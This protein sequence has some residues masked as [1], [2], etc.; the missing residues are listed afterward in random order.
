MQQESF[1]CALHVPSVWCVT[2]LLSNPSW[3]IEKETPRQTDVRQSCTDRL[4]Y[5]VNKN[6]V[7]TD[8]S[9]RNIED[10]QVIQPTVMTLQHC[11]AFALNIRPVAELRRFHWEIHVRTWQTEGQGFRTLR[12]MLCMRKYLALP[13]DRTCNISFLLL[14]WISVE[15]E[16]KRTNILP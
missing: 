4:G 15:A 8:D 9:S 16:W 7:Y 11:H 5:Y 12:E 13:V 2:M 1:W 10:V 14:F 3:Y 6:W